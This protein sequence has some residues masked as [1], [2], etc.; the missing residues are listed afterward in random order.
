MIAYNTIIPSYILCLLRIIFISQ[1]FMFHNFQRLCSSYLSGACVAPEAVQIRV[2]CGILRCA[3]LSCLGRADR[4][5]KCSHCRHSRPLRL[6]KRDRGGEGGEANRVIQS[7]PRG[8]AERSPTLPPSSGAK[9]FNTYC[10]SLLHPIIAYL[11]KQR[12]NESS[13]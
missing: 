7:A 4:V 5:P 8:Q 1:R 6:R 10:C 11:L 13:K 12:R 9:T 2:F 3:L